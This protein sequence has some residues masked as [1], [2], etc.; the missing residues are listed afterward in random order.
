M[1]G[2]G[3]TDGMG[4]G[5]EDG[6]EGE[7]SA[8]VLTEMVKVLVNRDGTILTYDGWQVCMIERKLE[9]GGQTL[10]SLIASIR[11]FCR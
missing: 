11:P 7:M 8:K 2:R 6:Q 4:W 9:D 10:W 5:A 3:R 1:V